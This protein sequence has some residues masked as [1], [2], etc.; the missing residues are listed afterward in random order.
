MSIDNED[1][2]AMGISPVPVHASPERTLAAAGNIKAGVMMYDVID[3]GLIQ[4]P[5][6][7]AEWGI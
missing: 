4:F 3:S 7:P 2:A 6:R 5:E 1:Q